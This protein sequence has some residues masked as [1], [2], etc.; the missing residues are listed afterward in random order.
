MV[1]DKPTD[2]GFAVP[3]GLTKVI[4]VP[5][6]LCFWVIGLFLNG[7]LAYP[8]L[9]NGLLA[10]AAPYSCTLGVPVLLIYCSVLHWSASNLRA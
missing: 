9:L 2:T 5:V 4:F 7:L 3:P 6:A 10:Y 8:V 1:D